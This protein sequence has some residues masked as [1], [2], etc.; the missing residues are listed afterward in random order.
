MLASAPRPARRDRPDAGRRE[1]RDIADRAGNPECPD[2]QRDVAEPERR[3]QRQP[4]GDAEK[5]GDAELLRGRHRHDPQR[6]TVPERDPVALADA[7]E[8]LI[9]QPALLARLREAARPSVAEVF[10]EQRTARQLHDLFRETV[11]TVLP[12]AEARRLEA[13]R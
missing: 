8:R 7:L 11:K 13:A 2:R 5:D 1:E 10:D 12:A 4:E 3:G 9:T 6:W